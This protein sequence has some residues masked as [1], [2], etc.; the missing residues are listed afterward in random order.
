LGLAVLERA[1]A[2]LV[3]AARH[4][5]QRVQQGDRCEEVDGGG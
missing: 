1:I 3:E 4:E 2:P 5:H